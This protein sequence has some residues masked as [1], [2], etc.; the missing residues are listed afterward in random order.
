MDMNIINIEKRTVKVP[1][2]NPFTGEQRYI[3]ASVTQCVET[4]NGELIPII[5]CK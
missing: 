1:G 4:E 2:W 3:E 5:D